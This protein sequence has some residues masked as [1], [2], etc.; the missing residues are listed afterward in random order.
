MNIGLPD[1]TSVYYSFFF[2]IFFFLRCSA[3]VQKASGGFD[4]M[5]ERFSGHISLTW[6]GRKPQPSKIKK[7]MSAFALYLL[8]PAEFKL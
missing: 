5:K 7:G 1:A 6:R 3:G 4:K 2:L 8:K